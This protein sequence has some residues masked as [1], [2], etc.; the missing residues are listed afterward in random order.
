[1][2]NLPLMILRRR[3]LFICAMVV[4]RYAQPPGEATQA[5]RPRGESV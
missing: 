5:G 2:I 4:T 3:Q 1:L